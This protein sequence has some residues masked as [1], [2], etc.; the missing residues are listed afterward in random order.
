MAL[1][2]CRARSDEQRRWLPGDELV[3]QPMDVI[4][5]A[6]TI[7]VPS[8]AVWPWLIQMGSGRAGWYAYDH[9]D[10]GG[11]PSARQI[12]PALQHIAVGEI[13]PALP[14]T[15]DAFVVESVIPERALVLV[16]PFEPLPTRSAPAAGSPGPGPRASWALV[17]EP[18]TRR[19]T[20]LIVR[21]RIAQDWLAPRP[22]G[23]SASKPIFIERIYGLLATMPRPL[24]LPVAGFGHYLMES[25]MLRGIKRRAEAHWA[26]ECVSNNAFGREVALL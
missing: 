16:V 10:N 15:Q 13:M 6:I 9:I 7:N 25:R 21:S 1:E 4:T 17:L 5:H 2:G 24:L 18:L 12:I 22:T 11:V 19:R 23:P 8:Q 3:P 20:R 26:T 14:G